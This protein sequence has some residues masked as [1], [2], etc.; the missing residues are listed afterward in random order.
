[1][2]AK[3]RTKKEEM[4][5]MMVVARLPQRERRAKKPMMIS[6]MVVMTATM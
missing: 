4:V 2:R 1:M 5:E 6:T 3:A